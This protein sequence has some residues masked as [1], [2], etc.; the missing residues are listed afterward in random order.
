[1]LTR[2]FNT[3]FPSGR[4]RPWLLLSLSLFLITTLLTLTSQRLSAATIIVTNTNDSGPGSL[5]QVM[6]DAA[7][8]DTLVFDASLSGQTIVLTSTLTISKDLTIDGLALASAITLSGNNEIRVMSVQQGV[9]ATLTGFVIIDG[10]ATSAYPV[11][12]GNP[13]IGAGL[14]NDGTVNIDQI[15]F[16][17]NHTSGYKGTGGAGGAIINNH[18]LTINTFAKG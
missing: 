9:A 6:A 15:T 11:P 8:G 1:M 17:N 5:R 2:P 7:P 3:L 16:S 18:V 12:S 4:L 14:L 13:G 10:A